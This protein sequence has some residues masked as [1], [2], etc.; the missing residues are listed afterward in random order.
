MGTEAPRGHRQTPAAPARGQAAPRPGARPALDQDR[1]RNQN[2][3]QNRN[4][5][6]DQDQDRNRNRNQGSQT[7]WK[8]IRS[9]V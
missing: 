4:Q 9:A 5:D 7:F 8:T 6:Q 3:N 1:N 2:Q